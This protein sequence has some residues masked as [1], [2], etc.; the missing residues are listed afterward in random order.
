LL[1]IPERALPSELSLKLSPLRSFPFSFPWPGSIDFPCSPS[2][3]VPTIVEGVMDSFSA[4]AGLPLSLYPYRQRAA[5]T[6][7]HS[8]PPPF[9][10]QGFRFLSILSFLLLLYAELY[11]IFLSFEF[12]SPIFRQRVPPFDPSSSFSGLRSA[13][14]LFFPYSPPSEREVCRKAPFAARLRSATPG[15]PSYCR[16]GDFFFS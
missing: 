3:L 4:A 6:I 8:P 13:L 7:L 5:E 15:A 11:S 16:L 2:S 14:P 1:F 12:C 10:R 9:R